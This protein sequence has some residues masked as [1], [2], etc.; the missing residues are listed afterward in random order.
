MRMMRMMMT[1]TEYPQ[2]RN[3][4]AWHIFYLDEKQN[5]EFIVYS[6]GM[7]KSGTCIVS[8]G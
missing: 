4:V 2:F 5:E 7:H 3:D 6:S 1:R 8:Y